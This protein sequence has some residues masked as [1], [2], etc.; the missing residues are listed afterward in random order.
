MGLLFEGIY[1]VG[2]AVMVGRLDR[3]EAGLK[4]EALARIAGLAVR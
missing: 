3:T 4:S 2:M 1:L